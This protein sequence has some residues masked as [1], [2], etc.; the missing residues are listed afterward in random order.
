MKVTG[1]DPRF[2]S[3][4]TI[5]S[6]IVAELGSHRSF[7]DLFTGSLAVLLAKPESSHETVNDLHG[8]L[9]NLA[10]VIQG[11]NWLKLYDRAARAVLT[12][13]IFMHACHQVREQFNPPA[14]G[15]PERAYWYLVRSWWGRN[16][17][18][19]TIG[20]GDS[21]AV[22]F[23]PGGGHGGIRYRSVIESMPEWHERLRS[24]VILQRDAFE[25]IEK[26]Q[27]VPGTVIYAD[28]PYLAKGAKYVHDFCDKD[29]CRL[30]Y[31]LREFREARVVVS[32]YDDPIARDLYPGWTVVKCDVAKSMVNSGQRDQTGRTEAPEILLING[33]SLC[34]QKELWT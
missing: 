3:K 26:I 11:D 34:K 22:R 32:Y 16:G 27:D 7:W 9:V 30:A 23:T 33:P 15:D 2:G 18:A 4:R 13:P 17:V 12:E 31:G 6:K 19:G 20:M 24:V 14:G 8:D 28:P 1:L 10:W 5:A 25:L 29:H 21:L